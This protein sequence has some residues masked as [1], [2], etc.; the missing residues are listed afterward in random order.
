MP[1]IATGQTRQR[2][3]AIAAALEEHPPFAQWKEAGIFAAQ[4]NGSRNLKALGNADRIG[5][6]MRQRIKKNDGGVL[7]TITPFG[8]Q[9]QS[10][11]ST[12]KVVNETSFEVQ[13]WHRSAVK[14]EDSD[15]ENL[16]DI[17]DEVQRVLAS[18]EFE[19][20]VAAE[21]SGV[22]RP[23]AEKVRVLSW[24]EAPDPNYLVYQISIACRVLLGAKGE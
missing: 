17:V 23:C 10:T 18:I 13:I 7:V 20:P 19:Y 22:T 15:L 5:A 1:A 14:P 21:L 6:M 2:G 24:E 12:E 11:G 16:I 9:N 3:E 4:F 8:G